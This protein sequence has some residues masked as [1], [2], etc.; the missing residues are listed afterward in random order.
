MSN[1]KL[2][3]GLTLGAAIG[4]GAATG[5][6][7]AAEP[8]AKAYVV[9]QI[10]VTNPEAY[11]RDYAS[12]VP[13]VLAA[14]HGQYL[15][16]GGKVVPLEGKAPRSRIAIIEF[17]SLAA[18]E[19]YWNSLEYKALAA[20]RHQHSTADAFIVEGLAPQR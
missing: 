7:A 19:R 17:P 9:A 13:P 4:G 3:I 2:V 11:T 1:R 18:A 6:H 14:L 10:D 5:L 20:I 15:A 8:V 16:R 12:K